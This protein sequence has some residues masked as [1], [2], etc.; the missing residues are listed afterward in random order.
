VKEKK[1][2]SETDGKEKTVIMVIDDED[3]IRN[4]VRDYL[5]SK[6]YEVLLASDGSEA[7]ENFQQ[8]GGEVDLVLLD[9]ILPE[10]GGMEVFKKFRQI[11]P[12]IK[13]ILTSGYSSDIPEDEYDETS[14]SFLQKP[15]RITELVEKIKK[16][17]DKH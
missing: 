10:I 13:A 12:K 4:M 7:L 5:T 15:F 17:L 16:L 8:T 1:M 11:N 6:G 9:M 2:L 3:I 14:F